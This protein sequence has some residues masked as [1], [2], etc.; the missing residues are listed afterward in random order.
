MQNN[1]N[2]LKTKQ[3]INPSRLLK[4][5]SILSILLISSG[6]FGYYYL[7]S[8]NKKASIERSLSTGFG[9]FTI[10]YAKSFLRAGA[11]HISNISYNDF[12][13][14]EGYDPMGYVFLGQNITF[15]S[16]LNIESFQQEVVFNFTFIVPDRPIYSFFMNFY[17]RQ[18]FDGDVYLYIKEDEIPI[19]CISRKSYIQ[20]FTGKQSFGES[21][22]DFYSRLLIP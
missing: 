17:S 4:E 9:L 1:P 21:V 6:I 2:K 22:H 7:S 11:D 13:Y 12:Y 5:F 19:H 14:D 20:N 10:T 15:S 16:N 18:G 3:T 8:E